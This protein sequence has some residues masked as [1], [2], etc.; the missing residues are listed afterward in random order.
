MEE[1]EVFGQRL[2]LHPARGAYWPAERALLLADL[3]L[4]KSAH[5]RRAGIAVP[6]AIS[7]A[8]FRRLTMLLEDCLPERVLFLGDLFHSSYNH[9]WPLFCRFLEQFP[10]VQFELIPGNHDILP[11]SA[12]AESRLVLQPEVLCIGPLALSHHPLPE[13]E[14]PAGKYNLCGHVHPCVRLLDAAG[15]G[16]KLPAFYFGAEQGI[17]PAFG[18]FTGCAEVKVRAG[19]QVFVLAEGQ[20]IRM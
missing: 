12:Y 15:N 8:N 5:F 6:P 16:L 11:P 9:V 10:G 3:H 20:V 1:V 2:Q 14:R 13:E 7:G 18:E 17:L 4:G 19:D